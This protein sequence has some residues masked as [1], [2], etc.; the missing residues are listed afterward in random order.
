MALL[1]AVSRVTDRRKS[2]ADGTTQLQ[3][4]PA[5]PPAP[6]APVVLPPQDVRRRKPPMLS[7]LLRRETL[8]HACRYASLLALDFVGV[9][10]AIFTA[11]LAK[12]VVKNGQWTWTKS[13]DQAQ[14]SVAFAYLLT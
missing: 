10:V 3:E 8:R 14:E 9:F 5:S 12:E 2:V 1:R 13:F 7:F 11:L 4:T 6:V